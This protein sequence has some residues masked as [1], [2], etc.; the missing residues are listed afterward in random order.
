MNPGATSRIC[1]T[2]PHHAVSFPAHW[3]E[4]TIAPRHS[5]IR[6]Q[7][8]S[9]TLGALIMETRHPSLYRY[10]PLAFGNS[11]AVTLLLAQ[12]F[13]TADGAHEHSLICFF[14]RRSETPA[15]NDVLGIRSDDKGRKRQPQVWSQ[16]F[17]S[18]HCNTFYLRLCTSRM[19][20]HIL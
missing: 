14:P 1:R 18:D 12:S 9:V 3:V 8:K 4:T 2:P 17:D 20:G 13:A 15:F 16:Q 7:V 19:D 6:T 10:G 11:L 5:P